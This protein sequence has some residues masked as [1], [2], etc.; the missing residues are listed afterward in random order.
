MGRSLPADAL[1]GIHVLSVDDDQDSRTLVRMILEYC[2]ALVTVATSAR[3]A[4]RILEHVV[5]DVLIVDLAMP[6]EDGYRFLRKIRRLPAASGGAIPAICL[7]G[8]G[9]EHGPERTLA[10]GFQLHL[11]KPVDPWEL[12]HGVGRLARR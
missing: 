3:H 8:H 2:G 10:A 5:P 9:D 7:T 4:R 1:V 12:C 6:R 11:T